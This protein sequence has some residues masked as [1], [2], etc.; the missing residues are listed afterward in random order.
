MHSQGVKPEWEDALNLKGG[1]WECRRDFDLPSL[2]RM[3]TSTVLALIGETLEDGSVI[4]GARVVDKCK[5]KRAEYRLEL[6]TST[7][8]AGVNDEIRKRLRE[9]MKEGL[10]EGG[11]EAGVVPDFVWKDHSESVVTA[12]EGYSGSTTSLSVSTGREGGGGGGVGGGEGRG[13]SGLSS[14]MRD[15]V[16]GKVK[17]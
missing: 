2:D 9:A 11:M 6:W 4:T 7:K 13:A 8:E 16:F 3:W 5:F 1:H 17:A 15:K 14:A 10:V 12:S